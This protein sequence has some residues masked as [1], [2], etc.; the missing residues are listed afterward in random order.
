MTAI[1][2]EELT[3][4]LAIVGMLGGLGPA[5]LRLLCDGSYSMPRYPR[6]PANTL[7]V[8][9]LE[10]VGTRYGVLVYTIGLVLAVYLMGVIA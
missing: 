5:I 2:R 10:T 7:K 4:W 3:R 8:D 1:T 9:E 6:V